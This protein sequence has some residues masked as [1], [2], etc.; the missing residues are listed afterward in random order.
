MS[1]VFVLDTTKQPLMPCS[2]R[3]AR[4]LLTRRKAAVFRRYPFTIILQPKVPSGTQ[5][6]LS[7][8][9]PS[10]P[11]PIMSP[12]RLKIDPGS[13][14]T[15]LAIVH[16][17][18]GEIVFAAELAHRG[19]RIRAALLE[20]RALRRNRRQRKTRYRPPRFLNRT[21]PEG[22]LPPS[23]DSRLANILTWVNRLR[24]LCP[25][26]ALSQE[27]VRFDTQL[28]QDAEVSGVGYQQGTLAGYEV[29]E[30]LLEKWHRTCAYCGTTDVPLEVEHIV[31]KSRGGSDRVSNLT[32]ACQPC[33]ERKG[34]QTAEE[35]GHPEVQAQAKTPLQDAAAIN[36]TRW[37]LYR[38]LEALGLPLE[39]GT[40]GRT[41]WNRTQRGLPKAHWLDAACVGASTPEAL[42][43]RGV[44]P[45]AITAMGHGSRQMCTTDRYGFPKT[46]KARA[47]SFLGF[48]TG[49]LVRADIPTGKYAGVH[50][51]RVVI[52]FQPQFKLHRF[53]VHPKYLRRLQKGDGY[54]YA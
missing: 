39:V 13:K 23:L 11:M 48:Q 8:E 16:D 54:A 43:I 20:R 46:H 19:R 14:T 31:P 36:A 1:R 35:F 49:D 27:L 24:R 42:E 37:A 5:L 7:F 12:L 28:M 25:I 33:N 32:L 53:N 21:R 44:V 29:R 38:R 3:R 15:G 34:N 4:I 45:L 47:K 2:P 18:T 50:V 41:K 26:G 17:G 10:R 6:P 9:E 40:G 52:R 30:Y 51:G 22:W